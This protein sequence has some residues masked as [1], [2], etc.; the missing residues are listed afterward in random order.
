[1]RDRTSAHLDLFGPKTL[2]AMAAATNLALAYGLAG[3][4]F[5]IALGFAFVGT[6]V[7]S[8]LTYG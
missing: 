6:L 2:I 1:M 4:P 5:G 7:G 8:W 3:L